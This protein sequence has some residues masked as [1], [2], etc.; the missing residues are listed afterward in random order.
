MGARDC[1]QFFHVFRVLLRENIDGVV[2]G[3]DSDQN[4]VSVDN[5]QGDQIV[6]LDLQG[7]VLLIVG[8]GRED[9]IPMQD[10]GHMAIGIGED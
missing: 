9:H 10:V 4:I 5:R 3:N 1:H 8:D 2:M 7:S 6:F